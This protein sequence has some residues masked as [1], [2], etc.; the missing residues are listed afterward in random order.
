MVGILMSLETN[1][2][3]KRLAKIIEKG[4]F[5]SQDS[6]MQKLKNDGFNITQTT[7]S[8]D[9]HKIG[10]YKV[11]GLYTMTKV[12]FDFQQMGRV[13]SMHFCSPNL[14]IIKTVPGLAH[15]TGLFIDRSHIDGVA[16]TVAGDDTIFVALS[17][18]EK[19]QNILAE[20]QLVLSE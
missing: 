19:Y 10:A 20:L 14:I 2:R 9:L 11:N 17:E 13:R 18:T 15:A 16:G 8:R 1:K 7:L 6:L 12:T 4:T 5:D 3:L